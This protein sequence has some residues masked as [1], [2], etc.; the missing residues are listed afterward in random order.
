MSFSHLR[1]FKVAGI[2]T[3]VPPHTV[4]NLEAG[5]DFGA[6]EVR[7]VV[8]MAGVRFRQVAGPDITSATARLFEPRMWMTT[9][10]LSAIAGQVLADRAM[11]KVASGGTDDSDASEVA[12]NPTGMPSE[13]NAVITATPAA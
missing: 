11:L 8:S 12:V 2:S 9:R 10:S 4:D 6:V 3:C 5:K 13:R 1:G 7:K